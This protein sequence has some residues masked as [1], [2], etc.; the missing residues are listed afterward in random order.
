MNRTARQHGMS[1]SEVMI[2]LAIS[3]MLLTAIGAAFNSSSQVIENNERFFR[4]TH[5]ARV[6][7]NQMVTE[8]RRSDAIVDRD[9]TVTA[10]T[11][12]FVVQGINANR[13]TI[14]RPAEARVPGEMVRYYRYD[15]TTK[16]L[17]L[18][19]LNDQGVASPEFPVAENVQGSPFSWDMGEDQNHATC[20]ARVAIALD[21]KIGTNHVRLS[22]SAAPRRSMNYQ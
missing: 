18:S 1:L 19:F 10:G 7:L 5:A 15:A 21:V 9:T 6:G 2:S 17:L 20:V 11:T 22:G 3:A 13:L 12:T 14:Y 8:V 4:A 16:R